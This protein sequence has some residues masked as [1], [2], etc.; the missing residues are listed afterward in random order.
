MNIPSADLPVKGEKLYTIGTVSRLTGI[1]PVTLRAWER[2]YQL[3]RP[4]RKQSGHRLYTSRHIDLINHIT[5]LTHRGLRISQIR[6][7]MLHPDSGTEPAEAIRFNPW[8]ERLDGVVSATVSFDQDRLEAIYNEALS[9]HPIEL[10]TRKLLKPA[11]IELGRRW[12]SRRGSVAEEHF[13]AF[14]LRNK[15]G[16]RFQH[17]VGRAQGRKLLVAG[18]PGELHELALLLFALAAMDHGFGI[19]CLGAN[20]P[21]DEL[22]EVAQ[23]TGCDAVVLSGSVTPA[24]AA[25]GQQLAQ[26]VEACPVPV[27]IGGQASVLASDAIGKAGATVLG[28]ELETGLQRL[29]GMLR[30]PS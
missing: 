4:V 11:L 12:E 23:R 15:L 8:R 3:I 20:M 5:A 2:R 18:L 17:Q 24:R 25:F 10:V 21:L 27:F 26:L 1:E 28:T 19:I 9:L 16:A 7:E 30:E 22:S 6:P 29:A 14:F 13:F